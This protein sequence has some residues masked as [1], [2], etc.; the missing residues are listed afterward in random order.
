MSGR[1]S[2]FGDTSARSTGARRRA[3]LVASILG[4]SIVILDGTVVGVALPKIEEDLG[5]TLADQTWVVNSYLLALSALLLVGGALGDR[6]GRK[7]VYL[8]GLVGF[9]VTSLICGLAPNVELL[10]LFRALQGLAGALLVP[11]T[12]AIIA[13]EFDE[14]ERGSAIGAWAA[15]SGLAA[16]LGPLVG[17]LLVDSA[18]WRWVFFINV[19][20][21]AATVVLVLWGVKE[22]RDEEETRWIDI[23]GAI[24]VAAG[25]GLATYGLVEG[26]TRGF[27]DPLVLGALIGGAIC[28]VLFAIVERHVANPLMPGWLFRR[29]NFT[30]ANLATIGLYAALSGAFFLIPIF[31]QGI[32]G[33]SAVAAG[34][35]L[36]PVTIL[37]LTLSSRMGALGDRFGPRWF[38]AVGPVIAALGLLLLAG[39]DRDTSYLLEVFPGLVLFGLGLAITVAPLTTAVM[40]SVS[41]NRSGLASGV[42]NMLSRVA[43]LLG[44][45]LLGAIVAWQAGSELGDVPV[46]SAEANAA[47]DD[48]EASPLAPAPTEGLD[49]TTAEVVTD[50]AASAAESAMTWAMVVAAI[51]AASAGL[52]SAVFIRNRAPRPAPEPAPPCSHIAAAPTRP[53]PQ[54]DSR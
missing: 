50:A 36:L 6:Y 33:W 49:P 9:G 52:I 27:G 15:W 21:I 35:A 17:G 42:N 19:P 14:S 53:V 39:I 30:A 41:A 22:S 13:A 48:V 20:V 28:L 26:P 8:I 4:L 25:L 29:P 34:A 37:M 12:L 3:T 18:G 1:A 11:L 40:D 44:I 46:T 32:A 10:I 54:P 2:R 51:L 23:P 5:A 7:R 43:G 16:A 31:L 24:L 45:A 47:L 38:M